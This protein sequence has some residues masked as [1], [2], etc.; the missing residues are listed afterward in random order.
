MCIPSA[1]PFWRS[2]SDTNGSGEWS[3]SV[4]RPEPLCASRLGVGPG[5]TETTTMATKKKSAGKRGR[6]TALTPGQVLERTFKGKA[7]KLKVTEDGFVLDRKS[8]KSL[9][10]AAKAATGYASISGTR[11]WM[12]NDAQ[13]GAA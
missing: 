12:G 8:Y 10:A 11:F 4:A 5:P 1:T 2:E 3:G 7:L 9:T 6:P 13:G